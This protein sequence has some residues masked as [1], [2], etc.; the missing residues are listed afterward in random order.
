M[1]KNTFW[2]TIELLDELKSKGQEVKVLAS[3]SNSYNICQNKRNL[4]D[5][6][7]LAIKKLNG[8]IGLVSYGPFIDKDEKD[9]ENNYLKHIKHVENLM[10]IDNIAIATD[11]MDFVEDLLKEDEDISL[12]KHSNIKDRLT[13][14]LSSY[15]NK[16]EIEKIMY[17]N[18]E[19]YF[20]IQN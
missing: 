19:K 8:I 9:L 7:I 6:Q 2:D 10:G 11:N 3:H 13:R 4:D 16:E 14:L 15:Y 17:R 12:Y 20:E 5:R 1:N 18:I